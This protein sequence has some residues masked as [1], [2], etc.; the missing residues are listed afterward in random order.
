VTL[1]RRWLADEAL[2]ASW[3]TAEPGAD[4]EM[5]VTVDMKQV[6]A[7]VDELAGQIGRAPREARFDYAGGQVTARSSGQFGYALDVEATAQAIA[8]A[9]LSTERAVSLAVRV[10]PPRVSL[11][12][13]EVIAPLELISEGRTNFQGSTAERAQNIR[14]ATAQFD[15]LAVPP[16]STFSFLQNLGLV[17][18]ANGYTESWVISGGRTVLGPGGG[19][20]Q[21]STTCFRAAFLGGF[22]IVERWP[23]SYRVSWYEPP[24]GLDAA[25]Y[26]PTTDFKFENDTD[27]PL[28][29]VTE[30]NE[31]TG[32]LVFRF[33]GRPAD[34]S[35]RL[36]GPVESD[37]VSAPAAVFEQDASL[38]IGTRVKVE[39]ARDGITAT[40]VRF[41]E[42]DGQEIARE[43][44]ISV[45]SAWP[46]QYIVGAQPLDAAETPTPEAP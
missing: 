39:Q 7:Y 6:R 4:G 40:I 14:V 36:E 24:L 26:S 44:L 8:A 13:L 32:E 2:L 30:V 3:L 11:S 18:T 41:I 19:V 17:T 46:A 1:T 37:P 29:I 5:Q 9:C 42:R 31:G 33:Y 23:H 25:V 20:C 27:E 16:H 22:P 15:G 35:V 45:Y 28:L 34:R 43:E 12:D 10:T 38:P 21:V